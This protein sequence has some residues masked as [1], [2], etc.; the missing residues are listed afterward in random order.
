MKIQERIK[1]VED[2]IA[3]SPFSL[4][5]VIPTETLKVLL[6][7]CKDR[8]EIKLSELNWRTQAEYYKDS[9]KSA[10]AQLKRKEMQNE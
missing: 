3:E 9:Y 6:S 5:I 1:L 10:K 4:S 2:M 8:E 7:H